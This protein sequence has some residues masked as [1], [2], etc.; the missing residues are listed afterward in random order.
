[1]LK[2]DP[3]AG[4]VFVISAMRGIIE[5]LPPPLVGSV[6]IIFIAARQSAGIAA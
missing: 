3:L 5:A 4:S 2:A 6:L 1:M